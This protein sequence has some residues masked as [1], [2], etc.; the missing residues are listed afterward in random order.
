LKHKY[1]IIEAYCP[2]C[3]KF[4]TVSMADIVRVGDDVIDMLSNNGKVMVDIVVRRVCPECHK[5]PNVMYNPRV[6]IP[7]FKY[8]YRE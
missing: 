8:T 7:E 2:Y 5:T 1:S 3:S 4:S 6:D